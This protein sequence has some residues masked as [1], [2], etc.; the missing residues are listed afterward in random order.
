MPRTRSDVLVA[1]KSDLM[2]G[3]RYDT[4]IETK[5]NDSI[6][7]LEENNSFK[8]MW[9][10]NSWLGG[11]DPF[12][13]NPVAPVAND[14]RTLLILDLELAPSNPKL[15][16][17]LIKSI[18]RLYMH[19]DGTYSRPLN[20]G[21]MSDFLDFYEVP[22]NRFVPNTGNQ[23]RSVEGPGGTIEVTAP[24]YFRY[25]YGTYEHEGTQYNTGVITF[26]S[27]FDS[28]VRWINM[29]YYIFTEPGVLEGLVY[30]RAFTF[31]V[32]NTLA[33]VA[34]S[35]QKQKQQAG[36]ASRAELALRTLQLSDDEGTIAS[37]TVEGMGYFP[38]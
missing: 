9:Q 21:L 30:D 10:A 2:R 1:I 12:A 6:R 5:L 35:A 22:Q 36:W 3:D 37:N 16:P 4:Q 31:L 24:K 15:D 38:E 19:G 13:Q 11:A 26:D 18:E 14:W 23:V 32:N 20:S 33:D 27:F 29:D 34:T 7:F 28:G 25:S 8:W 17:Q